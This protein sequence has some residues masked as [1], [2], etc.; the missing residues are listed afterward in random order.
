[1][2]YIEIY[3]ICGFAANFYFWFTL[4]RDDDY[5]LG[6]LIG[7]TIINFIIWPITAALEIG[8]FFPKG[9]VPPYDPTR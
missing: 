3:L 5:D 8:S 1:M 6:L 7:G 2:H 9:G 4:G